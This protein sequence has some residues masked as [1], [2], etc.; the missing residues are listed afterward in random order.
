MNEFGTWFHPYYFIRELS[1][2]HNISLV[3]S[4]LTMA[5][6]TFNKAVLT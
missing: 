3:S 6:F 4:T 5:R 1:L 2:N